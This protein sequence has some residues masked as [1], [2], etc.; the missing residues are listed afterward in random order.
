MSSH[1]SQEA[2]KRVRSVK[3]TDK[4]TYTIH[5]AYHVDGCPTK[6]SHGDFSGRYTKSSPQRAA[7]AA[8]NQLCHLKKIRGRCTLY[9]E[10]RETTQGSSHK[11]HSYHVK[12]IRKSEPF[13]DING[14]QHWYDTIAKPIK[15][16]PTEKCS[17]SHKSSGRMVGMHSKL[18]HHTKS[19]TFK[20][21][22]KKASNAVSSAVQSVR[23][24]IKKIL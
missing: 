19:R 4:K 1:K 15:H 14:N 6:F 12:R 8:V 3:E 21:L 10:M 7:R 22:T 11:I 16:I 17:K 13:V 9:I 5:K 18:R 23:K 24:S 20:S 2:H